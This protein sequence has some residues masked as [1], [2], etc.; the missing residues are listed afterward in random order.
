MENK[1]EGSDEETSHRNVCVTQ[2]LGVPPHCVR[3][4]LLHLPL[5][6]AP[7]ETSYLI[8]A[9][10]LCLLPPMRGKS[11]APSLFR[12]P[13]RCGPSENV[14]CTAAQDPALNCNVYKTP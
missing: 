7:V 6:K 8:S 3:L 10:C 9:S 12:R 11:P 4:F 13:Q 2:G 14:L 1:Q 5:E